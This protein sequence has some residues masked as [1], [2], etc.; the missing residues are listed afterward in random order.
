MGR[1]E[2]PDRAARSAQ[3]LARNPGGAAFAVRAGNGDSAA[4]DLLAVETAGLHQKAH[5]MKPD[6]VAIFGKALQGMFDEAH[7]RSAKAR[8]STVC[9]I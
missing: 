6:P 7:A 2:K 1:R 5:A 3:E 4:G 8:V 9:Q